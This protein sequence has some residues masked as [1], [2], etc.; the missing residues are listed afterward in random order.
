MA[1]WGIL[2]VPYS[3]ARN[4]GICNKAIM[5]CFGGVVARI[6]IIIIISNCYHSN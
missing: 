3:E 6:S 4:A 1:E 2:L 5:F